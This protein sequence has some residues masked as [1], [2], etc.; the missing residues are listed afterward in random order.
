M[1]YTICWD[2]KIKN[3]KQIIQYLDLAWVLNKQKNIKMTLIATVLYIIP[4]DEKLRFEG[5]TEAVKTLVE[6]G[7]NTEY[8]E[9]GKYASTGILVTTR[10][11]VYE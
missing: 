10:V 3:K 11:K 8:G 4:K 9:L 7:E 2:Y 6:I 5:R 1:R